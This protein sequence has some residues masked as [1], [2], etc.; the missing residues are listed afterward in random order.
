VNRV[1]LLIFSVLAAA[2]GIGCRAPVARAAENGTTLESI[3]VGG[4]TRT[5]RLHL[6]ANRQPEQPLPLVFNFH[7]YGGTGLAEEVLSGMDPAAD[8][9]GYVVVYPDGI[10]K[11]WHF[12]SAEVDDVAFVNAVIDHLV[13]TANV[14][15]DRVYATGISD[16]GFFSVFLGCLPHTRMAAI[17]PVAASMTGL[18]AVGCS[19]APRIPVLMTFGTDD[20]IVPWAGNPRF[21]GKLMSV[22]ETVAFWARHLG[23]PPDPTL[24]EWLPDRDPADGTNV[25]HT[26]YASG[27]LQLYP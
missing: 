2:T 5:Y 16:G 8:E 13:E 9:L 23:L 12:A 19:F 11:H 27:E 20:P 10:D 25:H 6:P 17:A 24:D 3:A 22:Q 18:Q 26:A 4:E 14:D 7:G 1:L 21:P 15:P